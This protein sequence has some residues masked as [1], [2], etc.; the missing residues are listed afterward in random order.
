MTEKLVLVGVLPEVI[1][2]GPDQQVAWVCDAG[3]LKVEFDPRRCP[4]SSDVFQDRRACV[5]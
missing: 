4:F 3:N 5:Y 1:V 2:I